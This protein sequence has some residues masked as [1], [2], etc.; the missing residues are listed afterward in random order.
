MAAT[1]D[2]GSVEFR[3]EDSS[4]IG[5]PLVSFETWIPEGY[6]AEGGMSRL[7]I[8][9][10][11]L[12]PDFKAI[13]KFLGNDDVVKQL[14]NC[15]GPLDESNFR[16]E[17]IGRF[18]REAETMAKLPY[19]KNIIQLYDSGTTQKNQLYFVME[20]IRGQSLADTINVHEEGL[21][22][23]EV[24]AIQIQ[25]HDALD[26]AHKHDI[27]HRDIK[28]D[29]ILIDINGI[30]VLTD[31]GV[32]HIQSLSGK[33][34]LTKADDSFIGTPYYTSKLNLDRPR[35]DI[36]PEKTKIF[37]E[38]NDKYCILNDRKYRVSEDKD[39][40]TDAPAHYY[41]EIVPEQAD[42]SSLN[43]P[44]LFTELTGQNYFESKIIT[45]ANFAVKLIQTEAKDL[46]INRSGTG[47]NSSKGLTELNPANEKLFNKIIERSWQA[48]VEAVAEVLA[49]KGY[50]EAVFRSHKGRLQRELGRQPTVEEAVKNLYRRTQDICSERC[51]RYARHFMDD[52]SFEK[53]FAD[54]GG[55]KLTQVIL[56]LCKIGGKGS[57]PVEELL[58]SVEKRLNGVFKTDKVSDMAAHASLLSFFHQVYTGI[59]KIYPRY[60]AKADELES[61]LMGLDA[62]LG[63]SAYD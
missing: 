36:N 24:C 35:I 50:Y 26:V 33:T 2:P 61:I 1:I 54:K 52:A 63:V 7:Y 44:V 60:K 8:A 58:S 59:K 47:L 56:S 46:Y 18:L 38:A 27:V 19:C 20:Y 39:R 62:R 31:F 14:G 45:S 15:N 34:L 55:K 16:K 42:I 28:P 22:P 37:E 41:I 57:A 49:L 3:M 6:F 43:G 29:N 4:I 21:L 48:E 25:M 12:I 17:R 32:S 40:L 11:K 53:M 13:V 5:T 23:E 51:R 9:K 10:H 30:V